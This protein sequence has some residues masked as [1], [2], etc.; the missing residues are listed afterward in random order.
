VAKKETGWEN[1]RGNIQDWKKGRNNGTNF[2][3][4]KKPFPTK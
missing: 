4:R 2:E 3:K 1:N